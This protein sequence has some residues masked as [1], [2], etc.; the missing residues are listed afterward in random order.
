MNSRAGAESS[1]LSTSRREP[2]EVLADLFDPGRII[3]IVQL[4]ETLEWLRSGSE[5]DEACERIAG[6]ASLRPMLER[7]AAALEQACARMRE[8]GV[9]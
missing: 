7:R 4:E 5:S 1:Q 8:D 9:H 6:S 2:W 3:V